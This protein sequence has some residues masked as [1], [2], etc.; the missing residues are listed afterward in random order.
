MARLFCTAQLAETQLTVNLDQPEGY[1]TSSESEFKEY[2]SPLLKETRN[3]PAPRTYSIIFLDGS[4]LW[5]RHNR[6]KS[7]WQAATAEKGEES[8]PDPEHERWANFGDQPDSASWLK[9]LR[10]LG[11]DAVPA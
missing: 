7:Y 9:T 4:A 2:F 10:N 11:Q 8:P 1:V 5:V 3:G 6:R